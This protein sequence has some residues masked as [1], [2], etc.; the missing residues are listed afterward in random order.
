[1]KRDGKFLGWL[2]GHDRRLIYTEDQVIGEPLDTEWFDIPK[3]YG[4][5]TG[6]GV[7]TPVA[8]FRKSKPS[9]FARW[10]GWP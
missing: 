3:H 5:D 10:S 1:M 6:K 2:V 7:L 4:I 8:V 9:D